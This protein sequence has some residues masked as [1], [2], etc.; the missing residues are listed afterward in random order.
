MFNAIEFTD[1]FALLNLQKTFHLDISEIN[2]NYILQQQKYHP[3]LYLNKTKEEQKLANKYSLLINE[4]YNILK[5][6]RSRAEYL[7][8]LEGVIVN[9]DERDTLNPDKELLLYVL[10]IREQ[11]EE[12]TDLT[13]IKHIEHAVKQES[14]QE[15]INFDSN[16][17]NK[18]M[19][20]AGLSI[21]K[22]RYL[23]KILEEIK[24]KKRI[25]EYDGT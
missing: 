4:A 2:K 15:F 5:S 21:I 1:F 23:E 14:S 7:L 11:I 8:E 25:I 9:T 24:L 19:D 10:N 18:Q 12:I 16:Y 20:K 13:K 6:P 3:D 17:Q 22:A